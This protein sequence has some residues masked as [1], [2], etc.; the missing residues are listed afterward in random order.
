MS[1]D[2]KTAEAPGA[3]GYLVVAQR[4]SVDDLPGSFRKWASVG[5]GEAGLV[6]Q[7]DQ[8]LK[9]LDADRSTVG[10]RFFGLGA[11]DR[12]CVWVHTAPFTA[13]LHFRDL[14]S[15]DLK[16]TDVLIAVYAQI[17]NPELFHRTVVVGRGRMDVFQVS[18]S[19]A[20]SLEETV[21]FKV[22]EYDQSRLLSYPET[23]KQAADD[24]VADVR[25][26]LGERGMR[27]EEVL[28]ARFRSSEGQEEYVSHLEALTDIDRQDPDAIRS[29]ESVLLER[30]L[31]TKEELERIGRPAD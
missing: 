18:A 24:L 22:S 12:G 1:T 27:V 25:R 19:V 10:W 11:S 28:F 16:S 4:L 23:Q 20:G 17:D 13:R 21:G 2:G 29:V 31:I 15:R 14:L 26:T 7:G 8:V 5:P 3:A 6:V 30:G 9:S